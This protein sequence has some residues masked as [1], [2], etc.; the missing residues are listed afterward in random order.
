MPVLDTNLLIRLDARDPGAEAALRRLEGE[1][2]VVPAQVAAEF[3]A[4]VTNPEAELARLHAS[5]RVVH[6]TDVHVLAMARLAA[7]AFTR[8]A[9]IRPRWADLHVGAAA[10]LEGTYVATTNKRHFLQMGVPAWHYMA[11]ADPPAG[12]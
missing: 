2:L 9:S 8:S 7:R 1:D 6:S 12:E 3:L 10:L 4:G 5:F 11:E